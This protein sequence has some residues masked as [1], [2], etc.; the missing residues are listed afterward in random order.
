VCVSTIDSTQFPFKNTETTQESPIQHLQKQDLDLIPMETYVVNVSWSTDTSGQLLETMRL[1]DD[2]D[3][4]KVYRTTS[5]IS[6]ARVPRARKMFPS[7]AGTDQQGVVV[8]VESCGNGPRPFRNNM[9]SS[10]IPTTHHFAM[11]WRDFFLSM[12]SRFR[13]AH[14]Y[15]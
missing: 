9:N 11:S 10:I 6:G 1:P 3:V 2:A 12:H 4:R 13:Q 15:C 8:T 5:Q 14:S 7:A